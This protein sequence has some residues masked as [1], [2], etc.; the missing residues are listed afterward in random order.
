MKILSI[1]FLV[2]GYF[3][4]SKTTFSSEELCPG[5]KVEID[6]E[7]RIIADDFT[8]K[9]ALSAVNSLKE[10]IEGNYRGL[11]EFETGL[12]R[13]NAEKI[14]KGYFLK[15]GAEKEKKGDYLSKGSIKEFCDFLKKEAFFY[16]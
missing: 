8:K 15:L 14:L 13:R 1:L 3:V 11:N 12:R 9:N 16:D 5:L 4:V 10:I 2:F 7:S 6:Q